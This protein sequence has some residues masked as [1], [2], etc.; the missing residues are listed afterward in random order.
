[1]HFVSRRQ[2]LVATLHEHDYRADFKTVP[3]CLLMECIDDVPNLSR[4]PWTI[5]ADRRSEM[6]YPAR[7]ILPDID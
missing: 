4:G 5:V 3:C 1:M 2:M 7:D 6:M